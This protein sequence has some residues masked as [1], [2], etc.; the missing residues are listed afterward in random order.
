LPYLLKKPF[1]KVRGFFV[2][3]QVKKLKPTNNISFAF[4]AKIDCSSVR[5]PDSIY[6]D[7]LM[8]GRFK[9]EAII[10]KVIEKIVASA[11]IGGI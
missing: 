10:R 6:Y 9:K 8:G 7:T 2:L 11:D 3:Y 4:I 5:L 1:T